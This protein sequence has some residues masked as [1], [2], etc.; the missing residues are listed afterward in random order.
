[1]VTCLQFL[2]SAMRMMVNT[3]LDFMCVE[4][5]LR[6]HGLRYSATSRDVRTYCGTYRLFVFLDMGSRINVLE[7]I[8]QVTCAFNGRAM[9]IVQISYSLEGGMKTLLTTCGSSERNIRSLRLS[10]CFTQRS[11]PPFAFT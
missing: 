3:L 10:S 4:T 7:R 1:M 6:H 8:N 9:E 5:Y 11:T 2:H